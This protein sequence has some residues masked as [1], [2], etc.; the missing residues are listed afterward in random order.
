MLD[1]HEDLCC[2]K[3]RVI[4][5]RL[6]PVLNVDCFMMGSLTIATIQRTQASVIDKAAADKDSTNNVALGI[7]LRG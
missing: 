7:P 3:T 6:P 5:P 4:R 1:Y 2:E